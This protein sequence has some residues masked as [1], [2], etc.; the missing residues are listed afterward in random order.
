VTALFRSRLIEN[1]WL[2]VGL[3]N[4]GAKYARTR[5]NVGFMSAELLAENQDF[6]RFKE[7]FHG[8]FSDNRLSGNKVA[9]LL[10]MTFMNL[11]G[12]SVSRASRKLGV[13]PER[14]IVIHDDLDIEPG[15]IKVKQ[16]GGAGGHNGL[17][18]IIERLGTRD[19]Y[20]IRVGIGRPGGDPVRYVLG[21]FPPDE[22]SLFEDAR[23]R[24]VDAIITLIE[25]GFGKSATNFNKRPADPG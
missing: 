24:V 23:Q 18:S 10:P 3:G 16:G 2:V 17:K 20:R 7:K 8:L 5:H 19:F 6:P 15:R 21:K 4:P 13:P 12:D 14:I 22:L 11:S 1:R 9:L 25:E